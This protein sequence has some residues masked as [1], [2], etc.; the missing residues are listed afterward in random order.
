MLKHEHLIVDSKLDALFKVHRWF[1]DW[2]ESLDAESAWVKAYCDH[3][4][5]AVAEGFTNAVRHAH[6]HL[7]PNTPI[8]IDVLLKGDRIEICIWDQGTPFDP[9]QLDE[10]EPGSLLSEG[11]YGWYLL[12]RVTDQVIYRRQNDKNCLSITQ[13]RDSSEAPTSDFKS[14]ADHKLGPLM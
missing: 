1:K 10:P 5:I 11:G 12:R 14:L 7:P 9:N 13:F 4:N 2:Y 6:A 3:L 8:A